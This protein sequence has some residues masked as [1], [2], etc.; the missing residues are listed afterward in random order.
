MKKLL[1][2]LF[3][4]VSSLSLSYSQKLYTISGTVSDSVSRETTIGS[5]V[6]VKG[7]TKGVSTNVYGFYSLTLPEGTYDIAISYLGYVSQTHH[8][9]LKN[10]ITLNSKL[11]PSENKL[12]EVIV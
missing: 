7:T 11:K 1:L 12:K 2:S 4:I 9:D 8:I 3:I 6:Y 5:L 10:N